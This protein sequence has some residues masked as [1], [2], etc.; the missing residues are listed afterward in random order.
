MSWSHGQHYVR[1]GLQ[2][3]Q[4]SRRAVDD[5]T[6]RLGTFKFASLGTYAGGTPYV[7]TSQQGAGRALYCINEFGSFFQDQITLS[8]TVQLTLGLRYDW[9]TFIPDNN[10]LAPRISVAFAPGSRKTIFRIGTGIFYYRTG[11]DSPPPPSS[12]TW[13][14]SIPFRFRTRTSLSMLMRTLPL[15]PP[16]WSGLARLSVLRMPSS[17]ALVSNVRSTIRHTNSRLPRP[18]SSE[19]LPFAR[20]EFSHSS[21]ESSALDELQPTLMRPSDEFSRSNRA[22]A[23]SSTHLI[24][25]SAVKLANCSQAKRNTPSHFSKQHWRN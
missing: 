4:F 24:F 15:C 19:C 22:A 14:S 6:N 13:S 8:P 12:A 5:L 23:L 10:N 3:P 25:P 16:T 20:R 7:F 1:A 21:F 18:G 17:T 11:G 9:Q 2:L